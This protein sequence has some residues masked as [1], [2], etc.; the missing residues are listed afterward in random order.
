MLCFELLTFFSIFSDILPVF[1]FFFWQAEPFWET[2]CFHKLFGSCKVFLLQWKKIL[3]IN[4][5]PAESPLIRL[6]ES[7][8]LFPFLLSLPPLPLDVLLRNFLSASQNRVNASISLR[9]SAS[10]FSFQV[11]W[12]SPGIV[13]SYHNSL[14]PSVPSTF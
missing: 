13:E 1:S 12:N 5:C 9:A 2:K 3:Q 14:I 10:Y 6:V 7:V 8:F 4:C 11:G